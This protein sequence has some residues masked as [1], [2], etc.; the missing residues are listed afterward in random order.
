LSTQPP[1]DVQN[2]TLDAADITTCRIVW[3][4]FRGDAY[5]AKL[6]EMK[7]IGSIKGGVKRGRAAAKG[8]PRVK[9]VISWTRKFQCPMAKKREKEGDMSTRQDQSVVLWRRTSE[10]AGNTGEQGMMVNYVTSTAWWTTAGVGKQTGPLA[11]FPNPNIHNEFPSGAFLISKSESLIYFSLVCIREVD[12]Q[13]IKI[14]SQRS[15][16]LGEKMDRHRSF[17]L[18]SFAFFDF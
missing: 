18:F 12:E 9:G 10:K 2:A 4:T 16:K 11:A 15:E 8:I 1:K 13:N 5:G 6:M 14:K 17:F 3:I 7:D